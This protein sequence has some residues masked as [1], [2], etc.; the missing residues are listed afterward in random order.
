MKGGDFERVNGYPNCW[1]WGSEDTELQKRC[2]EAGLKID[3]SSFYKIGSPE[4]LQLFDG[5][6]RLINR[7]DYAKL[8]Y[9]NGVEGLKTFGNMIYTID[10]ES[11]NPADNVHVIENPRIFYVNVYSFTCGINYN[12]THMHKYDI[13][14]P[15][16]KIFRPSSKKIDNVVATSNDWRNIAHRRL[17]RR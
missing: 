15:K 16:Y 14:D 6:E 7:G 5:V 1:G 17:V 2:L 9:D 8:K 10:E 3:R 4:I 13:R 12:R 11:K